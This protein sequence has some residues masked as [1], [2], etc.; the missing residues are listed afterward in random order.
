MLATEHVN[1]SSR[2]KLLPKRVLPAGDL[3]TSYN[4]LM[5]GKKNIIVYSENMYDRMGAI[6]RNRA[7]SL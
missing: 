7:S 3:S 4:F 1:F 6:N 5:K 2:V